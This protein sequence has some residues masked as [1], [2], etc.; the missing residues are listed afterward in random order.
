MTD[1]ILIDRAVVEQALKALERADRI[2]GYK[3]NWSET[4]ALRAALE[5]PQV[6]QK[7][8]WLPLDCRG[9]YTHPHPPRQPLT[10][11]QILNFGPGQPD[12]VWTYE[13]QLYFARA[14]EA[15]HGIGGAA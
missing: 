6:E 1:K 9:G 15:A 7:V 14:I 8:G 2:A 11:E 3:N 5:Q 12:A 13:D 10:D 4:V